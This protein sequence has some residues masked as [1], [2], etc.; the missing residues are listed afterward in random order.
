MTNDDI[1]GCSLKEYL[2]IHNTTK[3]KLIE[4]ITIDIDLL[5]K[6]L[7]KQVHELNMVNDELVEIIANKIESKKRHL[8]NIKNWTD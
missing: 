3:D 4:K 8:N 7:H 5:T 6:S 1:Y 2:N